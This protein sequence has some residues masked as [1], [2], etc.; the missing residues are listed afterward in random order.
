MK[1]KTDFIEVT[2]TIPRYCTF[3]LM[4]RLYEFDNLGF[5]RDA[6]HQRTNAP[7]FFSWIESTSNDN[8]LLLVDEMESR[9]ESDGRGKTAHGN[10]L[11]WFEETVGF[12]MPYDSRLIAD[13]Y[14]KEM[15]NGGSFD[16]LE[17]LL[18]LLQCPLREVAGKM[19]GSFTGSYHRRNDELFKGLQAELLI[20]LALDI[21]GGHLNL[22]KAWVLLDV[23]W[24]C[25]IINSEMQS[26]RAFEEDTIC[27][28]PVS[29]SK[30]NE[31]PPPIPD[32][33]KKNLTVLQLLLL[34][35]AGCNV[36]LVRAAGRVAKSALDLCTELIDRTTPVNFWISGSGKV[37]SSVMEN[38]RFV[39]TSHISSLLRSY[40][41]VWT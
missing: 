39:F 40:P 22:P 33:K 37:M 41:K 7:L 12:Q 24:F 36:T 25:R 31:R 6:A 20:S 32:D 10:L 9:I 17:T 15:L 14:D 3:T 19:E 4:Y 21:N 27:D 18:H 11:S 30:K 16:G 8:R 38:C 35:S 34:K 26:K 28:P 1:A 29:R 13:A 2:S 5:Y 23:S